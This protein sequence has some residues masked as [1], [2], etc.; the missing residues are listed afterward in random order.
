M[1]TLCKI[2]NGGVVNRAHFDGA[3]PDGWIPDGETWVESEEAQIGWTYADG[4]F[5]EPAPE[6]EPPEP[7]RRITPYR[8]VR[9]LEEA[10]LLSAAQ[11]LLD[12]NVVFKWRFTTA[13]DIAIDDTDLVAGLQ[14][15][16][17]DV[18]AVLAPG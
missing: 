13:P 5:T 7:T 15:I 1:T 14:A 3:M 12:A 17:A 10:G 9:R 4:T 16:G 8:I 6:P 2:E 11:A 18:D